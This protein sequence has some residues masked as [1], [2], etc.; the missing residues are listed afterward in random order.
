[1]SIAVTAPA[2]PEWTLG[3]RLLRARKHAGLEQSDV[4]QALGVSRSLV[5]MWERDMSDPRVGQV[6]ELSD[7]T[8]VSYDWLVGSRTCFVP[9][10]ALQLVAAAA[11]TY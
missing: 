11:D 5:S 4:A 6:R 3:D 8:G 1:M 2:E 7:L 10:P 9:P